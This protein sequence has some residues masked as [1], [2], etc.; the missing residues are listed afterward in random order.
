MRDQ[1]GITRVKIDGT[2]EEGSPFIGSKAGGEWTYERRL[3]IPLGR[4]I[5]VESYSTCYKSLTDSDSFE[6]LIPTKKVEI[7]VNVRGCDLDV[8]PHIMVEGDW[9]PGGRHN[10]KENIYHWVPRNAMLPHQGVAIQW[11]PRRA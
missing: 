8:R 3:E 4:P 9:T 5:K 1:V 6:M 10:E 7:E 2:A 11:A